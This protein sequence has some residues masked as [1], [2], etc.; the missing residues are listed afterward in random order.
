MPVS[1]G[2]VDAPGVVDARTREGG[3]LGGEVYPGIPRLLPRDQR[4]G[5]TVHGGAADLQE[6]TFEPCY[7][8][9]NMSK[10]IQ[11]ALGFKV[12]IQPDITCAIY[13]ATTV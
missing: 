8:M 1:D 2:M 12:I 3:W 6:N 7:L 13:Q 11:C 9:L 4:G 10:N 5:V